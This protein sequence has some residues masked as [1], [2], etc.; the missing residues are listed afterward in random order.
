MNDEVPKFPGRPEPEII[1][2]DEKPV[3]FEIIMGITELAFE[4]EFLIPA[5]VDDELPRVLEG[6]FD[7]DEPES[8]FT[9]YTETDPD[10][11]SP[12]PKS[13]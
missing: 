4:R 10:P 6:Q 12:R 3:P 7:P 5:D 13:R 2:R 1:G 8:E 9:Y 11:S